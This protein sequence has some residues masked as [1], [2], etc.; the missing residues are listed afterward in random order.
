MRR[1]LFAGEGGSIYLFAL[2][3][4]SILGTVFYYI[5][6][7]T[8]SF[9]GMSVTS[10]VSYA[11]TQIAFVAVVLIYSRVRRIDLPVVAKLRPTRSV[12]QYLLL[13]PIAIVS[14]AAF[15][16]LYLLFASFLGVMGYHTGNAVA[17]PV[18]SNFGVFVL[19]V[20]VMALLPAIG[21]ELLMRGTVVPAMT[22]RGTW[23]GIFISALLFALMHNNPMQTVYQFCLGVVLA[24]VFMSSR[25]VVPCM[26]L[27]FLSNLI[28]LILTAYLPQVIKFKNPHR[29]VLDTLII[30]VLAW[31]VGGID[32]TLLQTGDYVGNL[33]TRCHL[34]FWIIPSVVF[35][36]G[37]LLTF[38]LG[39]TWAGFSVLVPIVVSI[40]TKTDRTLLVPC[41]S[42]C[43]CGSV[44]GDNIS[45]ICDN[46]I[47]VSSCVNCNFI[48][49]VK[50]E[51]VYAVTMAIISFIGYLIVGFTGGN[52]WLSVGIPVFLEAVVLGSVALLKRIRVIRLN[53]NAENATPQEDNLVLQLN[54]V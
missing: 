2:C 39:T 4:A 27:H 52:V 13:L 18:F 48:V 20:F 34:P 3:G 11:V 45:P 6:A 50:T 42:A 9:D 17:M 40:C 7:R 1:N 32:S 25:S 10:W 36:V 49:H 41:I 30:L 22:S 21:E 46:T 54:G 33:I 31:A 35:L 14:I 47:L 43:L 5:L 23:F 8:G 19:A 28:T 12:G 24:L 37:A 15:F 53:R 26:I 29:S 44:F 51:A 16:P 38:S